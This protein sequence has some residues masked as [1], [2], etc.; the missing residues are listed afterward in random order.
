[1]RTN[2]YDIEFAYVPGSAFVFADTLRR[3][4]P[5]LDDTRHRIAQ[6]SADPICEEIHDK[7]LFAVA[8]ATISDEGSQLL[9]SVIKMTGPMTKVLCMIA[10]IA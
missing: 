9:L 5:E 4:Y 1:M 10:Q 3:A 8:Q 7:I 2:C 6:F